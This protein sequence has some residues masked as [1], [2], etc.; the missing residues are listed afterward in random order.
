M[1]GVLYDTQEIP[2][3]VSNDTRMCTRSELIII[4]TRFK[5][6]V[7][8]ELMPAKGLKQTETLRW[9][10]YYFFVGYVMDTK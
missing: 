7:S 5:L 9:V 6:V 8:L 2:L 1:S 4:P 3:W 10:Q